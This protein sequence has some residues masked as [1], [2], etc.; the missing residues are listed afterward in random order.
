VRDFT[1][2]ARNVCGTPVIEQLLGGTPQA[3]PDRYAQ[4]S[5][6]E[7]LP[8][9]A[10]QVLIVG[11]DDG[12]MPPRARDAYVAAATKAGD[13]AESITVAGA[14]HFETIAPT[15]AAWPLVRDKILELTG[16]P[17]SRLRLSGPPI[18]MG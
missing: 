12:V 17:P 15:S 3:V 6:L 16:T 11:A 8:F 10:R 5:P 14:G 18:G 9:G 4:A 2:Y 7:L 13:Q 1:T